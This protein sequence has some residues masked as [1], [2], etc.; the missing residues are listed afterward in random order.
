VGGD[1]GKDG[2][3]YGY[4]WVFRKK[5]EKFRINGGFVQK[6]SKS[7]G[8]IGGVGKITKHLDEQFII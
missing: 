7:Y 1:C 2:V 5:D 4:I 6:K 8:Y 3:I